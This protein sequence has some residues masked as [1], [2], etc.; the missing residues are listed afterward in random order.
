MTCKEKTRLTMEYQSSTEKFSKSV[1]DLNN[2]MG[3][4]SKA[5]YERLKRA[6]EK[7]RVHSEDVRLALEQHIAAHGC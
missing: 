5:E 1:S 4:S 7:A 3:K 6:S 2:R